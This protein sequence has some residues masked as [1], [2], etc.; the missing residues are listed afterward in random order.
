V[1]AHTGHELVRVARDAWAVWDVVFSP[2]GDWLAVSVDKYV[3]LWDTHTGKSLSRIGTSAGVLRIA[4]SPDG[5]M[6]AIACDN[7]TVE[8]WRLT[9]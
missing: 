3:R 5:T 6:L 8:L 7:A 9:E 1:D 2:R 4:F